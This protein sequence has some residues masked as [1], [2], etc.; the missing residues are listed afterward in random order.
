VLD[1]A[2]DKK[3]F[4]RCYPSSTIAAKWA[5]IGSTGQ[6]SPTELEWLDVDYDKRKEDWRV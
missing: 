1:N 3:V 2:D 6:L 5:T 4:L